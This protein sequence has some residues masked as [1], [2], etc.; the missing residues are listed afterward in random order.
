MA[1]IRYSMLLA[2]SLASAGAFAY[3]EPILDPA[4]LKIL[5]ADDAL[6]AMKAARA[7]NMVGRAHAKAGSDVVQPKLKKFDY[8][9]VSGRDG[10][11][12][13]GSIVGAD[14]RL[15]GARTT[16]VE[17]VLIPLRIELTGTV[18]KVDPT[19][20]DNGCISTLTAQQHL[21]QSNMFTAVPNYTFNGENMGNVTFID[22]FQRAQ[23]WRTATG[24]PLVSVKPAYHL[25]LPVTVA[26]VQTL[27][28]VNGGGN[29]ASFGFNGDCGTNAISSDN[30]N[31]WVGIDINY[32]DVKLQQII[33]NLGLNPS[34]FPLFLTYRTFITDG[35]P[36]VGGCCILGYH[37]ST[38]YVPS[39]PGQ[40]YGIA[41]YHAQ[42]GSIFG[43]GNK[44]VATISHE[45]LEW[46]NDPSANNLT[47]P[48][49]NIGQVS[50]CQNNLE[51]GDPM[52]GTLM[53]GVVMPNGFT[54]HA[55]EN[56][57]FSWFLGAAFQG[58]GGKYSSGS[59]FS[60]FAK[61]CPPGGTN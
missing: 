37:N 24:G 46:I 59:T 42:N 22:G 39:D 14:P 43:A 20:P 51:T 6:G 27:V 48:W 26:P 52:S 54:Y 11:T 57:Y 7:K 34:Q 49:G 53:P 35:V 13:T 16:S 38:T 25:A 60:G 61:P 55:Q 30:P 29:A 12:Y 21:L 3:D 17:V 44:N 41:V 31:R 40:T 19:Q 47:P 18:R 33:A 8:T 4:Q 32:L 45:I 28:E 36:G 2:A 5:S 58:A 15:N 23:F 50:G 1:L 10:G 9:V 56:A